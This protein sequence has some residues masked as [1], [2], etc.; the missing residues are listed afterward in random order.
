MYN[1][2]VQVWQWYLVRKCTHCMSTTL[3]YRLGGGVG[4]GLGVG[5]LLVVGVEDQR[6]RDARKGY[7]STSKNSVEAWCPCSCLTESHLR[8]PESRAKG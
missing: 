1:H 6:C 5:L 3:Q 2:D 8:A 4:V 7:T